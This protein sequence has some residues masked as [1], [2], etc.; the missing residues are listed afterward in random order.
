[1]VP[2]APL[3][4]DDRSDPADDGGVPPLIAGGFDPLAP[5]GEHRPGVRF[6]HGLSR[7]HGWR[8]VAARLLA[9]AILVAVVLILL[10]LF[11]RNV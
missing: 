4:P 8:L 7:Q 9:A 5:W 1:V 10:D 2:E 6:A 11:V 3:T